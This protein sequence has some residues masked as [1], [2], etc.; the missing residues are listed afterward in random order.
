MLLPTKDINHFQVFILSLQCFYC[1]NDVC[2]LSVVLVRTNFSFAL[3]TNDDRI[4]PVIL[5][6]DRLPILL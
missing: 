2:I 6:R 5:S 1:D 3:R 4:F